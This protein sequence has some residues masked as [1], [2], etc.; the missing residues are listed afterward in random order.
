MRFPRLISAAFVATL[1]AFAQGGRSGPANPAN[2]ATSIVLSSDK[3]EFTIS[4]MGGRFQ[5]LQLRDGDHLSPYHSIGHFLALDG[6]GAPTPQEQAAGMPFHGEASHQ[7]M[8]IVSQETNGPARSVVLQSSLPLAQEKLTRTIELRDGE[9]VIYVASELESELNV[10]RPVSWAE[11][12]TIGPPFLAPGETFVDM[13]ATNCRV[14]PYKPGPIPGNLI[15]DRNFKWPMAPN[16]DLEQTD[17]RGV[18]RNT[19]TLDLASCEMD[20]SRTTAFVTAL[21]LPKRLLIGYIF[22]R[23][24]YPWVMSWMNF[25]GDEHAAR[26]MEFSTQPF[27]I[28]HRETVEMNPLFGTPTFKWLPAKS[29]I[30]SHFLIFYTS[31]PEGFT[32]VDDVTLKG[33]KLIVADHAAG[34]EVVLAAGRSL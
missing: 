29:K 25:T 23:Q 34:K 2:A 19:K 31:V 11:H 24:E 12:A 4:S 18:P 21:N 1:S 6:F 3:L 33:G 9:N 16:N 17:I 7:P 15:Y 8:R 5:K 26:G 22:P 28:S 20:P 27:D 13:S 30:Q 32:R 10:D 14:R